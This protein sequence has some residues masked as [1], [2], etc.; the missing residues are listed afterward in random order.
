MWVVFLV[1]AVIWFI[2][3]T[4]YMGININKAVKKANVDTVY[5]IQCEKCGNEREASYD[6]LMETK[7][8]KIKKIK[9][10]VSVGGVAGASA[11]IYRKYSKKC[12]C[13]NCNKKRWH[14]V[15]DYYDHAKDNTKASLPAL[16]LYFVTLMAGGF[17]LMVLDKIVTFFSGLGH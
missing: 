11:A 9:K 17:V 10:G 14:E 16:L 4:V 2:G 8:A 5:H 15:T 3:C 13:P 1:I 6:E 7:F 12:S